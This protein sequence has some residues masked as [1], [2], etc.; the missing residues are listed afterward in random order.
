[1]LGIYL[2]LSS[3]ESTCKAGDAGDTG[4]IPG[5][6]RFPGGGHGNLLQHSYLENIMDKGAWRATVHGVAESEMT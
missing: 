6:G 4:S 5:W 2:W 1:M 3:K